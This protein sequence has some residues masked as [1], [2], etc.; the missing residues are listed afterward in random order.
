[1]QATRATLAETLDLAQKALSVKQTEEWLA[2]QNSLAAL[3]AE[4]VQAWSRQA[5]DIVAAAQADLVRCAHAQWE[6]QVRQAKTQVEGLAK[7]AP[8]GSE[9]AVAALDQAITAANALY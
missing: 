8:A 4:K 5:F 6:A 7:S 2:L 3:A 9:A 1:M